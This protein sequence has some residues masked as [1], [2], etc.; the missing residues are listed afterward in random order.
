LI[1]RINATYPDSKR[2]AVL[3]QGTHP[4]GYRWLRGS[5]RFAAGVDIREL[6]LLGMV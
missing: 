2:P 1:G 3:I 6:F 5:A 4:D